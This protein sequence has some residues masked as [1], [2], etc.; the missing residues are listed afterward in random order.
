M[1]L[2][3]W[4]LLV[5]FPKLQLVLRQYHKELVALFQHASTLGRSNEQSSRMP[6]SVWWEEEIRLGSHK[7]KRRT[8]KYACKCQHPSFNEP[9]QLVCDDLPP[10][11]PRWPLPAQVPKKYNLKSLLRKN[12]SSLLSRSSSNGE[13]TD[14]DD[15]NNEEK[16]DDEVS[17]MIC[18]DE[19]G[20]DD[21]KPC[22]SEDLP[23]PISTINMTAR[24]EEPATQYF[25]AI[26]AGTVESP[27]VFHASPSSSA[28]SSSQSPT[29]LQQLQH[30]Q[31]TMTVTHFNVSGA[32]NKTSP[33]VNCHQSVT[34]SSVS[35]L[36]SALASRASTPN[37]D[38]VIAV[39][40]CQLQNQLCNT[41]E[42][43]RLVVGQLKVAKNQ[44]HRLKGKLCNKG[45]PGK[46]ST[47]KCANHIKLTCQSQRKIVKH[48]K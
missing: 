1:R 25:A 18:D 33:A 22:A 35:A 48:P 43:L 37:Q 31:T 47:K 29:L 27:S 13:D 36:S 39:E 17:I 5:V 20:D 40:N 16:S 2:L 38:D 28:V 7:N 32:D 44:I 23:P 11:V 42:K 6:T 14:D 30:K 26:S 3:S 21:R 12:S 24:E 46:L 4:L 19:G 34:D 9:C 45:L 15:N 8:G 41:K 10:P